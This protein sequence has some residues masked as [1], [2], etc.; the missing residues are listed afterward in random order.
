MP[1]FTR[2]NHELREFNPYHE[3]KGTP[4]GGRFAKKKGGSAEYQ[5]QKAAGLRRTPTRLERAEAYAAKRG[6]D[7]RFDPFGDSRDDYKQSKQRGDYSPPAKGDQKPEDQITDQP[8]PSET[9]PK[10]K[11]KKDPGHNIR[12][13]SSSANDAAVEEVFGH[14]DAEYI[15]AHMV[16]DAEEV[17]TVEISSEGGGYDEDGGVS[18]YDE[19]RELYGEGYDEYTERAQEEQYERW[20]EEI[21]TQWHEARESA[22]DKTE[23]K[24]DAMRAIFD[25][26]VAESRY[27]SMAGHPNLPEFDSDYDADALL[28]RALDAVETYARKEG[29]DVDDWD[30]PDKIYEEFNDEE[31]S[32]LR[33]YFVRELNANPSAQFPAD[34]RESAERVLNDKSDYWNDNGDG[35]DN[36][37]DQEAGEFESDILSF[38]RWFDENYGEPSGGGSSGPGSVK[39]EFKGQDGSSLTRTFSRE[40]GDLVVHH[41]YFRASSKHRGIGKD[42]LRSHFAEY[43]RIGV[44]K[45]ETLANIDIGSYAWARYGFVPR[46]PASL[47]RSV[48]HKAREAGIFG[49]LAQSHRDYVSRILDDLESGDATAAW[50]LSDLR[51]GERNLGK[52]LL[53]DLSW[54][55]E[56]DL[57]DRDQ[58]ARFKQYVGAD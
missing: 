38:E 48:R 41:D 28:D 2:P 8:A 10:K 50:R 1:I 46:N 4:I 39:F 53:T 13:A 56:L 5:A 6:A 3:P 58:V 43:I 23:T 26:A 18:D 7:H 52:E 44:D 40:S 49:D 55:A 25:E 22:L 45:I 27:G 24:I 47:A 51:I 36:W 35:Y 54:N 34:A 31:V 29:Y 15:A 14:R 32:A 19:A 30:R 17:F 21:G 42:I 16:V 9:P 11:D 20:S 33:A 57:N 37:R 12:R